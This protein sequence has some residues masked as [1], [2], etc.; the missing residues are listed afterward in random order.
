M[1]KIMGVFLIL[2]LSVGC[3][4]GDKEASLSQVSFDGDQ[5][6]LLETVSDATITKVRVNDLDKLNAKGFIIGVAQ[7]DIKSKKL[8]FKKLGEYGEETTSDLKYIDFV[9]SIEDKE[10][11]ISSGLS[12]Q[13]KSTNGKVSSIE[14]KKSNG[15]IESGNSKYTSSESAEK[16]EPIKVE[17]D[18]KYLIGGIAGNKESSISGSVNDLT[19]LNQKKLDQWDS[20]YGLYFIIK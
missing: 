11:K 7:Q 19:M 2:L 13:G 10:G 3:A 8:S 17:K 1:K 16:D 5:V 15:Q 14:I 12:F 6:D 9:S 20:F 4:K 18:T